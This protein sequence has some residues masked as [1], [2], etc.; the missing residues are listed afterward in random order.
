[1]LTGA[2]D[3]KAS[4]PVRHS[5]SGGLSLIVPMLIMTLH[6]TRLTTLLT[7]SLCI[8]AVAATLAAAMD[9]AEPK[10]I[11]AATA[12]YA[13]VLV[14]FVGTGGGTTD[15]GAL[16]GGGVAGIV[17]GSLGGAT[18]ILLAVVSFLGL[19][20]PGGIFH[21]WWRKWRYGDKEES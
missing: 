7:S 17:V 4:F 2:S 16:S 20:G 6:Q 11:V 8:F 19:F 15:A 9:T 18:L 14:V 1:M 3:D 21:D 10:D 12:A 13:A 5:Q